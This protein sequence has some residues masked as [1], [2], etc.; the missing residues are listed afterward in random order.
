VGDYECTIYIYRLIDRSID[1]GV[2]DDQL[3]GILVFPQ[4]MHDW[5]AASSGHYVLH[6]YVF[7]HTYIVHGV[8]LCHRHES[9]LH[10]YIYSR[11]KS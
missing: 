7:T 9:F 6:M 3:I 10:H 2:T 1:L 11:Q 8:E 4:S 5:Q